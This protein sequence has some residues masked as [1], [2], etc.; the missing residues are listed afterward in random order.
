MNTTRARPEDFL[1]ILSSHE[2]APYSPCRHPQEGVPGMTLSTAFY[3]IGS[4]GF[5]LYKGNPCKAVP[6][7]AFE[8]VVL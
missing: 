4:G 6:A 7:G 8:D 1:K 5:R 2:Y 3:D